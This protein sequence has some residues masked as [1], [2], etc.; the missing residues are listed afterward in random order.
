MQHRFVGDIGDFGKYALLRAL[1]GTPEVP[2]PEIQLGVVWYY[3]P[4]NGHHAGTAW[5]YLVVGN[6]LAGLAGLD[7][8]LYGNLQQF[9]GPNNRNLAIVHQM[10]ILPAEPRNYFLGPVGTFEGRDAW[11]Q[12]AIDAMHNVNLLYLDPNTGADIADQRA[13]HQQSDWARLRDLE[14]FTGRKDQERSLIVFQQSAW[15]RAPNDDV[16]RILTLKQIL[17]R[18]VWTFHWGTRHF[19]I[20][21]AEQHREVLW[22]NLEA[23]R[24][25]WERDLGP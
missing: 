25:R 20:I 15:T 14:I 13:E 3:T 6:P 12:E 24:R 7:E 17:Q 2:N 9:L 23:F 16:L 18:Q 8:P 4:N 10:G 5:D 1:C 11:C 19:L 21:P 22:R